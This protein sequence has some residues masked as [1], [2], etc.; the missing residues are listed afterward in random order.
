[1]LIARRAAAGVLNVFPGAPLVVGP[2]AGQVT[3]QLSCF[4]F[5]FWGDFFFY[6]F[7]KWQI[8]LASSAPPPAQQEVNG[9]N[10]MN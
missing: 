10:K 9:R 2:S 5:G 8:P 1:M 7:R 6:I 4:W 3:G